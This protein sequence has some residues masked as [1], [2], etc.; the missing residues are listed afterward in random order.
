MHVG[1]IVFWQQ[2]GNVQVDID[3]GIQRA[4]EIGFPAGLERLDGAPQEL[5]VKGESDFLCR[6]T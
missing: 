5:G 2:G 6:L 4:F 1:H 3:A